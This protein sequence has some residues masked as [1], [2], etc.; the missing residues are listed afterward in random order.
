[1]I[2][3]CMATYNGEKYI[4]EQIDSILSQ[5]SMDDELII[6]DDGSKDNTI[7]IIRKYKDKR[8]KIFF[9]KGCHGYTPNFENALNHA[10]GDYIFLSD[11]DDVWIEGKVKRVM[12]EFNKGYDFVYTNCITINEKKEIISE[13]RIKD[14]NIKKGAIR[15][16]I[17]MRY[18]GCCYCFTKK[19]LNTCLPFPKKYKLLEHDAWI[20]T[21]A[22]FKFKVS[23]I[24]D[25]LLIY[26]RHGNNTSGGGITK[27]NNSIF[28]MVYRRIY[29][30][31]KVIFRKKNR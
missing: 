27:S 4:S 24:D 23:I 10:K 17:K 15:T 18:L 3:V 14:Y 20:A 1:M 12:Q 31:L 6:S 9:N 8:I 19:V 22:N 28:N 13:S 26:R 2:S 30:F 25:V 29:R 21:V 7:D 5:L 16:I 11:Q